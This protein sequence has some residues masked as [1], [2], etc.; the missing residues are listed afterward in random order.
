MINSYE[1]I[2]NIV[3]SEE[4]VIGGRG[5]FGEPRQS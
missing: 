4:F 1:E 2:I 5:A 3:N